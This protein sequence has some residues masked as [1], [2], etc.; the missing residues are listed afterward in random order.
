MSAEPISGATVRPSARA[1]VLGEVVIIG[2]GCYGSFYTGQ[3]LAGREKGLLTF[4]RLLVIDRDPGCQVARERPGTPG[5][6]VVVADWGDFLDR[7]LGAGPPGA[8]PT[9]PGNV[10]VPSPFM[11][12]LLR[13]WLLR[14]AGELWPG[15]EVGSGPLVGEV[16]TP[17]ERRGGD[18]ATYLSWADWICPTHCTEPALCPVIRAPRTWSMTEDLQRFAA[19]TGASGPFLFEVRHLAHGVGGFR[20]AD[21]LAARDRLFEVGAR[22]PAEVVIATTSHCHAAAGSIRLGPLVPGEPSGVL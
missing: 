14:R 3:L 16:G 20:T 4:E 17:Y 15:R 21:V 12:H 8:G 7:Y 22:G 19:R 5:L 11:P 9:G 13:E 6:E 1:T 10:I 2:G 18:Q